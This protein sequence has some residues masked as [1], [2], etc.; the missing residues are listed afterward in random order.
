MTLFAEQRFDDALAR[1]R[2]EGRYLLVD[3]TAAW[4]APC[5]LMDRMTWRD[6]SVLAW[7]EA[8]AVAIQVDVDEQHDLARSLGIQA[9]PTVIVFRDG[10]EKDRV[11]G[12]KKPGELL[13]W[14]AG[15]ERGE[16]ELDRVRRALV[17]PERDMHG[18]LALAKALVQGHKLDEALGHYDWLWRNIHRI[19]PAMSGVRVSFM[20]GEIESLCRELPAARQ[21]FS[22][23]RDEAEATARAGG[24]AAGE[25]RFEWVVLNQALGD[26]PRTLAWFDAVKEAPAE[27]P[28]LAQ[29][30]PWLIPALRQRDRWAD[31]GRLVREPLAQIQRDHE[32]AETTMKKV[33]APLRDQLAAAMKH[34]FRDQAGMLCRALAAA[35][36]SDEAAAVKSEALRLD[37]SADMKAALLAGGAA[38]SDAQ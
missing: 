11:V 1:A 14:L 5:K 32:V 7:V 6:P 36:R 26:V 15:V 3:A 2:R 4:C 19:E 31:I 20:A 27:V 13:A 18:R 34:H 38:V 29:I 37:D 25:A 30:G 8:H 33:P 21:R 23:I 10:E 35:G 9:M 24:E 22:E 12:L 16:T 28:V 17:D